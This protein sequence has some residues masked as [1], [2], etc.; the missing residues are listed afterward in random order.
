MHCV[1]HG[2][3]RRRGSRTPVVEC[4]R[5]SSQ[6]RFPAPSPQSGSRLGE[7]AGPGTPVVELSGDSGLEVEIEAPETVLSSLD[8][9]RQVQVELPLRGLETTGV[10]TSRSRATSGTAR[11]FPVV[12]ALESHPAIVPG[13]TVEV[14][15][16]VD[17]E[18]ALQVPLAAVLNPGSTRPGVF[19]VRDGRA[20]L[21]PVDV[22]RL[23]GDQVTVVADL[24]RGE[25][26]VVAGHTTLV[27][28]DH[29]EV[30]P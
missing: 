30:Q 13:A 9:G 29:V 28:G 24:E 10:I 8:T 22:R 3:R 5:P 2:R 17:T 15:L 16:E 25:Q 23:D 27:D 1:P 11:L 18:A 7:W 12:V 21:V 26:I 14:L 19:R 4:G 20:E 6:H